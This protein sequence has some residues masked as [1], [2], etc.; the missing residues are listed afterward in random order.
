[1]IKKKFIEPLEERENLSATEL[2]KIRFLKSASDEELHK[3]GM[4]VKSFYSPYL[5]R[6]NPSFWLEY[7]KEYGLSPLITTADKIRI[8][9]LHKQLENNPHLTAKEFLNS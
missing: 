2:A 9:C 5:E 3:L 1:M 8:N 7:A 6:E 4:C